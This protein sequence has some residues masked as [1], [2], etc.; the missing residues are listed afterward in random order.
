MSTEI[1]GV[2]INAAQLPQRRAAKPLETADARLLRTIAAALPADHP[3]VSR[4]GVETALEAMAEATKAAIA[5]DLDCYVAWCA[6]GRL[7]PFPANAESLV[8]R[9]KEAVSQHNLL[10]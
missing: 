9:D 4:L 1:I 6:N 5:A 7:P 10:I 3:P 2:R 8:S